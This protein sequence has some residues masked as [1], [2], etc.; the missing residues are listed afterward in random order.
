[1]RALELFIAAYE[2]RSFTQAA[3]REGATQSGVSQHVRNLEARHGVLLFRRERG[4]VLPT[5][6]ADV[7]YQHCLA[8]LRASDHAFQRLRQFSYGLSGEARLGLMPTMNAAG[9]APALMQFRH[10]HP[11]VKVSVTEAYSAALIHALLA[12]ELDV[13]VVP[14]MPAVQ[15]LRITPFMTTPEMMV[16]ARRPGEDGG[17]NEG[18]G[19][20]RPA[21]LGPL[22]LV[23]PGV[24]N[25]RAQTVRSYLVA[26]GAEIAEV[27]EMNSMMG[28]LDLIARSDWCAILPALLMATRTYGDVFEVRPLD[29]PMALELVMVES[30]AAAL[31]PPAEAFCEVLR[32]SC[33]GLLAA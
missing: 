31:S 11:N 15:G 18:E 4:R 17:D 9:L 2:E 21:A 3:L 26:Q 22:K 29:P 32:E 1:M 23:L 27:I 30:A 19:P 10:R 7:F 24:A 13:A 5:P 28:T 6:A 14:A 12:G 33:E 25:V 8:A 20:V 16:R